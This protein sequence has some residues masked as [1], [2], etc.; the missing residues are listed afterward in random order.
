VA[1]LLVSGCL[2]EQGS[3]ELS[4][5]LP[6]EMTLRPTGMT[7][8]TVTATF[9]GESPLTSTSVLDG[10]SFTASELPI[11]E[12]VQLGVVL[13]DVSNRI[14]G[15][16]EAGQ[17]IDLVGDKATEITIPVRKPFVYASGAMPLVSFDTT[18]D[19]RLD[20]F[21]GM[22]GGVSNPLF[23]ISVGGDR[24]AVVTMS[25]VL[26][27]ATDTNAVTGTIA[28]P[29]PPRDATAV[30]GTHKV[31]V[32]HA[33]GI[34][35]VD[36]DT[37][38]VATAMVGPV[39]RVTAGPN[40]AGMLFA[41]GLVGRVPPSELPPPMGGCTAPPSS[42]VAI[43]V[44]NPTTRAPKPVGA[45]LADIAA[46][47]DAARLVAADPCSG[48][49]VRVTGDPTAE[50]GTL[51][52]ENIAA[53]ERAAVLTVAGNR[54]VV[55][56]TD[57]AMPF[58]EGPPL[59]TCSA[60]SAPSCTATPQNDLGYAAEGATLIVASISLDGMDVVR[61][62]A[63]DRRE[64]MLDESDGAEQHAQVLKALSIV[65]LDLV[66]LPGGQFVSVIAQSKYFIVALL[67]DLPCLDAMVEDWLLFDLAS[68]AVAHRVRTFCEVEATP[69]F[70]TFPD[71]KCG[72]PPMSEQSRVQYHPTSVGAL[73]GAR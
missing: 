65:P 48:Q 18:I 45:T 50:V 26:V 42:I 28:I 44:D 29:S 3:L 23:T 46:A 39:D 68:S 17:T 61:L 6:T 16:G 5:Q 58:C 57:T 72:D 14:V 52:V 33:T 2:P 21:Q 36:L 59:G 15:V 38:T 11:G 22:V 7:T 9:P 25:S 20:G 24:L 70:V 41:Y 1:C 37:S 54:I 62:V 51:A 13:R 4:L 34:T 47:P 35:I 40:E 63:P 31:A 73:F 27:I 49:V 19:P 8:V 56:G 67:P 69:P 53:I 30:P 60:N 10:R 12:D 43:E 64:T 55:A 66:T 32:A 71:W